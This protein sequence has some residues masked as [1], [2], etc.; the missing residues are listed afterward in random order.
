[1]TKLQTGRRAIWAVAAALAAVAPLRGARALCRQDEART[2][3]RRQANLP[4]SA[5]GTSPF[6]LGAQ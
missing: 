6:D 4:G 1:M 5:G 3:D 2:G